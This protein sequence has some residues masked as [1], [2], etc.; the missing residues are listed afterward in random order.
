[1]RLLSIKLNGFRGFPREQNFDLDADAIVVIGANGHGKTSLFDGI[2]WALSGKLPRLHNDDSRLVSM[3]SE[4]GQARVELRLRDDRT[5]DPFSV[6]RSFDG[7]ER[8]VALEMRERTYQGPSAEGKLIDLIWPDAAAS[9]EPGEALASLLTCCTY[10]QQDLIRNFVEA[11]SDHDRFSAVSE[12]IGAGRVTELQA[13][14]ERSK[15]AWSTATNQRQEELGPLRQRLAIV[16][17][18]L[19]ELTT[20][21]SQL[22][23]LITSEQWQKWWEDLTELNLKSVQVTPASRE[24]PAAIDDAI[25]QLDALRRLSERRLDVLRTVLEDLQELANRATPELAPLRESTAKLRLELDTLKSETS[26]EQ[27]RMAELRRHQAELREKNEQLKALAA[28]A[29]QHLTDQCPVCAQTYDK[30][31]TRD[32]LEAIVQGTHDESQ[33]PSGPDKL[34]ELLIRLEAKEKE[35]ASA[36]SS[37]HSTEHIYNR[38]QITEQTIDKRLSEIGIA[39]F[40]ECTREAVVSGAILETDTLLRRTAEMQRI[41]ESLALGLA[42][43]SAAAVIDELRRDADIL[44]PDIIER[45]NVID[46]RNRTGDLAQRMIEGLRDATSFV[47]EERLREISPLL[48]SVWTR[49]DPHPAFRIVSFFSQMVRGKGQLA[50]IISDPVEDKKCELPSTVLSSSQLNALAVSVF[51][52]LNIGVPNPPL[53]VAILDDPLQSL[54]DINLLGLVDLFRRT[55]ERRQLFVSTH[56]ARFGSLLSRKLR[57]S[58]EK[59]RTLVIELNAWGRQGPTVIMQDVKCDPVSLRL[60]S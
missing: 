25:K 2:L 35:L 59:G 31:A 5:G 8:R 19:A 3:Y 27:S 1:M 10:L 37:L 51:L 36:E 47:L 54:D 13:S 42:Q 28:L 58:S 12:L 18:R 40:D 33:I 4:T 22:S 34:N 56:D 48:Q 15:K 16:E 29:L 23:P 14:L 41:G 39:Q 21:S 38:R 11:A 32:R 55:K 44:R 57:P 17:T 26:E 6:T 30:N 20:R 53:A 43:S 24:A 9:A 52:S 50:T 45:E 60:V 49:I 46:A 7:K